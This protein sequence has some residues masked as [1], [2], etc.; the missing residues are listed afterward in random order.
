MNLAD[1]KKKAQGAADVM[2]GKIIADKI[3]GAVNTVDDV[4]TASSLVKEMNHVTTAEDFSGDLTCPVNVC[5]LD[6]YEKS[7]YAKM[8]PEE[9]PESYSKDDCCAECGKPFVV[10]QSYYDYIIESA[11][12]EQNKLIKND[13]SIQHKQFCSPE[14][15][16]NFFEKKFPGVFVTEDRNQYGARLMALRKS[17]GEVSFGDKLANRT[18]KNVAKHNEIAAKTNAALLSKYDENGDRKT[19][20]QKSGGLLGLLFPFLKNFSK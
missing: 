8:E 9:D 11:D 16:Q 1:L 15:G 18:A 20:A 13:K 6:Y 14:C 10:A 17:R 19:T 12:K 3:Q 7:A 2:S 5:L 4:L